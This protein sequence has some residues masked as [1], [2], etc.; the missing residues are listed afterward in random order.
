MKAGASSGLEQRFVPFEVDSNVLNDG[1]NVLCVSVHQADGDSSD[2]VLD[3]E[4]LGLTAAEFAALDQQEAR[5]A[6]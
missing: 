4:L 5:Q 2:L 6:S 3:V 1:D